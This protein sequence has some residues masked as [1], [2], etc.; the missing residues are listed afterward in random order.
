MVEQIKIKVNG[1]DYNADRI[2][3]DDKNYICL[4]DLAQAGFEIGYNKRTKVP[5]ISNANEELSLVVDDKETSIETV[6]ING[7]N[8][9]PIRSLAAA[10]GAFEVDYKDGKV[11][12]KT[13]KEA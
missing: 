4:Q 1:K 13:G 11:I 7:N 8:Y 12:V 2:L 3:K 10:T 6:N 5:S 9:V